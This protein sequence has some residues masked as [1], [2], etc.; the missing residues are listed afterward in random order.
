MGGSEPGA[1]LHEEGMGSSYQALCIAHA[2]LQPWPCAA[3]T[4]GADA[5]EVEG[6]E[7]EAAPSDQEKQ[8]QQ[9]LQPGLVTPQSFPPT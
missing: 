2:G 9:Q 1:E 6:G 5:E 7:A 3:V 8:Q 4:E